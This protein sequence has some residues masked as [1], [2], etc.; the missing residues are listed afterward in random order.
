M[1]RLSAPD[2]RNAHTLIVSLS[3][4][5]NGR[6]SHSIVM[7][8]AIAS[9]GLNDYENA[10]EDAGYL[11]KLSAAQAASQE[12]LIVK[13]GKE[14]L[15]LT[16]QTE[17]E[18]GWLTRKPTFRECTLNP[19]ESVTVSKAGLIALSYLPLGRKKAR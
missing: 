5:G 19:G 18:G 2:L 3:P 16:L 4:Y 17:R 9:I 7:P 8:N 12:A 10:R 1:P 13:L 11:A 6:T 14:S 15:P